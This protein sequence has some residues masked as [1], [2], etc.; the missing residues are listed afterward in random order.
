MRFEPVDF[1]KS[2]RT[3]PK[4]DSGNSLQ[5]SPAT[6]SVSFVQDTA[7]SNTGTRGYGLDLSNPS[8]NLKMHRGSFSRNRPRNQKRRARRDAADQRRLQSASQW[9][10]AGES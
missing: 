3:I 1:S 4:P 9:T 7:D 8:D 2:Y 10:T 5:L 6:S